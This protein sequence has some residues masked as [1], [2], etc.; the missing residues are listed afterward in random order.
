MK[1]RIVIVDDHQVVLDGL[2]AM[3][4][5]LRDFS[6]I[7]TCTDG[8]ELIEFVVEHD[9]DMILMDISMPKLDGIETMKELKKREIDV[10]VVILSMHLSLAYA[11][12]LLAIGIKGYLPKDCNKDELIDALRAVKTGETYISSSLSDLLVQQD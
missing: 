11:K 10:P 3:I 12:E 2:S 5:S 4:K 6:V 8:W 1:T 9:V 7:G